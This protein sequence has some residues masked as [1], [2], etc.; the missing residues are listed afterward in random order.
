MVEDYGVF[1]LI[2]FLR[3]KLKAIAAEIIV[4]IVVLR[5]IDDL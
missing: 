4:E 5:N 2:G 1:V 3:F